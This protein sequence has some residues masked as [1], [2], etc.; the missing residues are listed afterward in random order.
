[1]VEGTGSVKGR[2]RKAIRC[3]FEVDSWAMCFSFLSTD[4][5]FGTKISMRKGETC[6]RTAMSRNGEHFSL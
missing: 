3:R 1:V 4:R 6:M 2:K 5:G